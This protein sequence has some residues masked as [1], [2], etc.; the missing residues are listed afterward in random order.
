MEDMPTIDWGISTSSATGL[1]NDNALSFF[2]PFSQEP[3]VWKPEPGQYPPPNW[4][5]MLRETISSARFAV[6]TE[7]CLPLRVEDEFDGPRVLQAP[8][9]RAWGSTWNLSSINHFPTILST[10]INLD[11]K[12]VGAKDFQKPS[13]PERETCSIT[14]KTWISLGKGELESRGE[15]QR[16]LSGVSGQLAFF[17]RAYTVDKFLRKL[18]DRDL[19][20]LEVRS[21][22][23]RSHY[24]MPV[25]ICDEPSLKMK[26][27]MS[28]FS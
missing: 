21:L 17:H 28:L 1:G 9:S 18:G 8:C 20:H 11:P 22:N 6:V 5:H 24:C 10:N 25:F 3:L 2:W 14:R 7:R 4:R 26:D 23:T 16:E 15:M 19:R 27:S 13:D 12:G